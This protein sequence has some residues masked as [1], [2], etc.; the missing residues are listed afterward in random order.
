MKLRSAVV[1]HICELLDILYELARW[2]VSLGTISESFVPEK[3]RLVHGNEVL[4]K[5][6]N[7]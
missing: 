3:G 6:I 7:C 2:S 5:L 4:A 1:S